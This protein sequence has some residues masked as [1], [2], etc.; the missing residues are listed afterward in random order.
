LP[1]SVRAITAITGNRLL[2]KLIKELCS[3]N[4]IIVSGLAFGIDGIALKAALK[5][6]LSTVGVLA[7]GLNKIYPPEHSS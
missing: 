2:K 3:E 1:S 5:N 6:N 4:I 7:H